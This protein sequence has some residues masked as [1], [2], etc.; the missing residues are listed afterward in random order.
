M[1]QIEFIEWRLKDNV[2]TIEE[3]KKKH[4][5]KNEEFK[6]LEASDVNA[7]VEE[8]K[9]ILIKIQE[10][11]KKELDVLKERH[12]KERDEAMSAYLESKNKKGHSIDFAK[13]ELKEISD[14]LCKL[15]IE[16]KKLNQE[17]HKIK[18]LKEVEITSHA[19]VQYLNRARG[20]NI[21]SIRNEVA[22]KLSEG[23]ETKEISDIKD[24]MVVN[25]LVEENRINLKEVE[26]DILPES[27]KKLI[28]ANELIGSTGTFHTNNGFRLAVSCGKVVTFLPRKE[29]PMK[30]KIKLKEK[31]KIK[32]MKL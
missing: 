10:S 15:K 16:N 22:K 11:H 30:I 9:A 21:E 20:M 25:F 29:K 8:K 23:G 7:D 13:R 27:V 19:V 26:S 24:H 14:E 31:R 5:Q 2:N 4:S 1:S 32:K 17:K 6:T 28:T 18:K 3:L 12:K